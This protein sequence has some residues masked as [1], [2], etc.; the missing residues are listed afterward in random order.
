LFLNNLSNDVPQTVT[1]FNTA[2][3]ALYDTIAIPGI[4]DR[5]YK[6]LQLDLN[7]RF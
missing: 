1:V 2:T 5:D 3:P 6:R 4:V 7:F